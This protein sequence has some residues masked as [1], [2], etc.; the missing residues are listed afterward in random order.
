M[1]G[2]QPVVL[3]RLALLSVSVAL[4]AGCGAEPGPVAPQSTVDAADA[5]AFEHLRRVLAVDVPTRK[6]RLADILPVA[7]VVRLR[8]RHDA[9]LDACEV[10]WMAQRNCA[11]RGVTLEW[12][13]PARSRLL[14]ALQAGDVVEARAAALDAARTLMDLA[15]GG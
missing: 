1:V 11:E 9:L 13:A 15:R 10:V 2:T 6:A 8:E 4:T 3:L 7:A 12:A 14:S 5:E